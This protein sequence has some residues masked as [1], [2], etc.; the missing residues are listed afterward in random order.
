MKDAVIIFFVLLVIGMWIYLVIMTCTSTPAEK[1]LQEM[2]KHLEERKEY[3]QIEKF[4]QKLLNDVIPILKDNHIGELSL[5]LDDPSHKEL[6]I[7]VR[8]FV[9]ITADD[10]LSFYKDKENIKYFLKNYNHIKSLIIDEVKNIS[11][12]PC[13]SRDNFLPL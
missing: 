8:P 1:A 12:N 7:S 5:F 11:Q 4:K 9:K 3:K 2:F 6:T 10:T 13:T